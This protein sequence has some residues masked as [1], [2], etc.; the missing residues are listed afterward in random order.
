M[1]D[2]RTVTI[3][4][5]SILARTSAVLAFVPIPGLR[6]PVSI[7]RAVLSLAVSAALYPGCPRVSQSH[8][9]SGGQILALMIAE[10]CIGLT[11][12]LLLSFF[13]E[14]FQFS[15]Q[16][17]S[18]QAGFSY[19]AT[20]DPTNNTDT[21]VLLVLSQ[22]L[23][24]LLALGLGLDRQ[25]VS[26]IGDS[27][28]T[29]PPGQYQLTPQ[30]LADVQRAGSTVF[31]LGATMALPSVT[32]F[33]CIDVILGVLSRVEQQLQLTTILFPLKTAGSVAVVILIFATYPTL[34]SRLLETTIASI[35]H[36][37][38]V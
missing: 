36:A 17:L 9:G 29:I 18:Q 20:I 38:G 8:A 37:M 16:M 31:E 22:L 30:L 26:L 6:S 15:A 28:K 3:T 25:I 33:L 14:V 2:D 13:F 27:L 12:G 11:A 4:F 32:V 19:A 24:G 10:L 21:G 7:A 1:Y 23:A 34:L 5:L 35:R